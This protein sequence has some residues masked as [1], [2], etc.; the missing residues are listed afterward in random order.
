[1]FD[2]LPGR[3]AFAG[4]IET[5]SEQAVVGWIADSRR[6]AGPLLVRVMHGDTVVCEGVADLPRP[7]IDAIYRLS[8]ARGF[9]L[10][11]AIHPGG[12]LARLTLCARTSAE[13]KWVPLAAGAAP[14]GD[15]RQAT[16][17]IDPRLAPLR[18]DLLGDDAQDGA[19]LQGLAVLDIGCNERGLYKIAAQL[20][21]SRVVI[22]DSEGSTAARDRG[23]VDRVAGSLRDIS[24]ERFDVIFL[25]VLHLEEEPKRYLQ[26]LQNHLTPNGVLICEC[27]V[28]RS[29][30]VYKTTWTTV[31]EGEQLRRYPGR[32]LLKED[33]LDGY[34]VRD[35]RSGDSRVDDQVHNEIFHCRVLRPFVV[36]VTGR[37]WSGKTEFCN[38]VGARGF[39]T[40]SL[41]LFLSR[42]VQSENYDWSNLS[43]ILRPFRESPS[44]Q[45]LDRVGRAIARSNLHE[46][47]AAVLIQDLS[48]ETGL[49]F[50][51]GEILV[52]DMIRAAVERALQARGVHVWTMTPAL[53]RIRFSDRLSKYARPGT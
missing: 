51:E 1:M 42:I 31:R 13:R 19:P 20:G 53:E 41:D 10:P 50:I 45:R 25:S 49:L 44:L 28:G 40:F 22:V 24:D 2:F 17:A 16:W 35:I 21:A 27:R 5:L 9:N 12:S 38:V 18:L 4:D 43:E 48:L 36:L 7:D 11:I 37:G 26:M 52:H 39:R 46:E 8:G 23:S 15:A 6:G 47:F 34:S 30:G 3:T 14:A 32:A 33:L 29:A